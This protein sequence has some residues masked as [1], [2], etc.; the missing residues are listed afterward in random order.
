MKKITLLIFASCLVLAGCLSREQRAQINQFWAIQIYRVQVKIY[1]LSHRGT[2]TPRPLV[3]PTNNVPAISKTP[4][5]QETPVM[6]RVQVLDVTMDTETLPGLAPQEE[7][8]RMKE[9]WTTVQENNQ[10]LLQDLQTTFG[11]NVKEKAF[12]LTLETE[13]QLK[14]AAATA[15]DYNTY[16][17][18]QTQLLN[19]QDKAIRQLMQQNTS[20]L[21]RLKK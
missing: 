10:T 4:T 17:Q 7:R 1:Q 19:E 18:T 14:Q 6:P 5:G 2:S 13:K 15:P 8:I 21:K 12:F 16:I 9:A 3:P 20:S 11:N